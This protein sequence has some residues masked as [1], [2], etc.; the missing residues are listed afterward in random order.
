M[1]AGFFFFGT[2]G[3]KHKNHWFSY[4]QYIFSHALKTMVGYIKARTV[5]NIWVYWYKKVLSSRLITIVNVNSIWI[6][7][8]FTCTAVIWNP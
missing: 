6:V 7:I 1:K 2:L 8:V 4:R 5:S 3:S